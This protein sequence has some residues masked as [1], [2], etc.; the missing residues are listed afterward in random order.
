M[1]DMHWTVAGIPLVIIGGI[2]VFWALRR[3]KEK[4]ST[5]HVLKL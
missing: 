4:S 5:D 1:G 2:A 3:H